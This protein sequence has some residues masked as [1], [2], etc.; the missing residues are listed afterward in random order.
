MKMRR[1]GFALALLGLVLGFSSVPPF[2]VDP[3]FAQNETAAKSDPDIATLAFRTGSFRQ[4]LLAAKMT[5]LESE[6]KGDGPWTVFAPTD[7]AIGKLPQG[8]WF[9][10]LQPENRDLLKRVLRFHMVPGEYPPQRL[11]GASASLYTIPGA[12]GPLLVDIRQGGITVQGATAAPEFFAASN[13]LIQAVD[14]VLIP[15]G[16]QTKLAKL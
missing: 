7:E 15:K 12:G 5:G 16:L 8:V 10:L 14:A 2:K 4:F 11:T 6:L 1:F 13:G 3:A 9:K